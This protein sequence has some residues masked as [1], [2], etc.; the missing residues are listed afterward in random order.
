MA[1]IKLAFNATPL[2]SPLTGIGHYTAALLQ[3]LRATEDLDAFPFYSTSWLSPPWRVMRYPIAVVRNLLQ[4]AARR[5]SRP[6][7]LRRSVQQQIFDRGLRRFGINLYHEPNYCPMD[8]N[9]PTVV[10]V[11]DMAYI[12][13]PETMPQQRL[14]LLHEC[15]PKVAAHATHILVI[16]EFTKSELVQLLGVPPERVTVTYPGVR[17]QFRPRAAAEVAGILSRHDL[18]YGGYLLFVGTLEPRKNLVRTLRA[19]GSLPDGMK[20]RL[21]LVLAGMSGWL[22]DEIEADLGRPDLRPFVRLLD[23]VPETALPALFSGAA[24]LVYPS[25][26]EGFGMPLTEAMACGIPVISSNCASM[27][28]VAGEAAILV[29]PLD[30]DAIAQAIRRVAENPSE[31]ARLSALGIARASSFTWANCVDPTVQVYRRCV[32]A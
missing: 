12:R 30:I 6:L 28:E 3:K 1:R 2:L 17:S 16:S 21:P 15:M 11:C 31:A 9:G 14:Q 29:N 32:A 8:F 19:Y 24:M 5:T 25:L 18:T 4:V 27:P 13:H 20:R 22:T 10:T 23:Y 7:A 26:Y